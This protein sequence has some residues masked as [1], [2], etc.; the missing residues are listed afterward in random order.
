MCKIVGSYSKYSA[1]GNSSDAD[2]I[3]RAKNKYKQLLAESRKY[4][5]KRPAKYAVV[6]H[7][8]QIVKP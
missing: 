6:T 3:I 1:C 2:S 5:Y 7:E 4:D 8:K